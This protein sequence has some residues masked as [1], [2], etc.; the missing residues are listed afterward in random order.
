MSHFEPGAEPVN[1]GSP[2]SNPFPNIQHSKISRCPLPEPA[3]VLMVLPSIFQRSAFALSFSPKLC[4]RPPRHL[5]CPPNCFPKFTW[6]IDCLLK[7]LVLVCWNYCHDLV[8]LMLFLPCAFLF[9]PLYQ[10]FILPIIL[11]F[12]FS[13]AGLTFVLPL[14]GAHHI[15]I[16]TADQSHQVT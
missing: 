15:D 5:H 6:A 7:E 16:S 4:K 2:V 8:I 10:P 3:I 14:C 12:Q 13:W 11:A 1:A 9:S